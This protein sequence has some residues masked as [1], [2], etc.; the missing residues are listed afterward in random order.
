MDSIVESEHPQGVPVEPPWG[1][2]GRDFTLGIVSLGSKFVLSWLNTYTTNNLAI[3]QEAVRHRPDGTGLLTVCN[4]T[5]L[6][7]LIPCARIHSQLT[8]QNIM[9]HA[10]HNAC[11]I[12]DDAVVV[13]SPKSWHVLV[14]E[15]QP[16]LPVKN[17]GQV[18]CNQPPHRAAVSSHR[19][20]M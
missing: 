20:P 5:R 4:H 17:A 3:L 19:D 13:S 14:I 1:S 6:T 11:G 8:A 15:G 16:A 18:C 9:C 10:V 7:T 12:A 2:V